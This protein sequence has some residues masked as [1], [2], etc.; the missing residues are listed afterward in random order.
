MF[1][2]LIII[3]S[4][5]R[6]TL[7]IISQRLTKFFYNLNHQWKIFLGQFNIISIF[8]YDGG[9]YR[10]LIPVFNSMGIYHYTS[11]PQTTEHNQSA[12]R[13]HRHIVQIGLTL[14]HFSSLHIC[15]WSY[16]FQAVVYLINHIYVDTYSKQ[17]LPK[18]ICQNAKL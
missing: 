7:S 9:E 16:A 4:I 15:Y 17:S 2:L 11:P 3:T 5:F 10:K 12:K 6:C 13:R 18:I 14:L 8:S 1:Y